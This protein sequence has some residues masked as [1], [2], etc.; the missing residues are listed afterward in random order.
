MSIQQGNHVFCERTK[1]LQLAHNVGLQI[2]QK[3]ALLEGYQVYLVEQWVCDRDRPYKTVKVF[4]GDP[5]HKI[6]VCVIRIEDVRDSSPALKDLLREMEKDVASRMKPV[7]TTDTGNIMV[8]DPSNFSS[9]LDMVLVP[10]GD[11]EKH[12]QAFCV[13]VN[14]RRTQCGGRSALNLSN[15]TDAQQDKFR[16]LYKIAGDAMCFNDSVLELVQLAQTSLHIFDLL[17][18]EYIDGLICDK[19]TTALENFY[20]QLGPSDAAPEVG[21]P[22]FACRLRLA[23]FCLREIW[24]EPHLLALLLSKLVNYKNKLH[25]LGYPHV[26]D[27]FEIEPF[28]ICIAAFQKYTK[29]ETQS[30]LLD[31]LTLKTLNELTYSTQTLKMPRVLKSKIDDLSVSAGISNAPESVETNDLET[32][33]IKN[34]TIERLKILWRPKGKIASQ[35]D[36]DN[37]GDWLRGGKFLLKTVGGIPTKTGGVAVDLIKNVAGNVAGSLTRMSAV[38]PRPRMP[39]RKPNSRTNSNKS[40]TSSTTLSQQNS[41]ASKERPKRMFVRTDELASGEGSSSDFNKNPRHP[42]ALRIDTGV[43]SRASKSINA[44]GHA[45][46]LSTP[47]SPVDEYHTALKNDAQLRRATSPVSSG[48]T[49][50][51]SAPPRRRQRSVSISHF[52]LT[53]PVV[54]H[55]RLEVDQHPHSPMKHASS[56][57]TMPSLAANTIP[58]KRVVMDVPTYILYE[59]MM[60]K[61]A[62][63]KTTFE[64]LQRVSE[65]LDT[66]SDKL[67]ATWLHRSKELADLQDSARASFT[68]QNDTAEQLKEMD[69]ECA[70]LQYELLVLEDKLKEMEEFV[71]SFADKVRTKL[72]Y[73][74]ETRDTDPFR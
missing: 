8:T 13:N 42:S 70:K 11:F 55:D 53:S 20:K 47:A 34:I 67:H 24:L 6:R 22:S 15:P 68:R 25:S 35:F 61:E 73:H 65:T 43:S 54:P 18:V 41:M 60:Q 21:W 71:D 3:D 12:I 45:Q 16:M 10:D 64:K 4:T 5:H 49:E 2:V 58:R 14:L 57:T 74:Y 28:K 31:T 44:M 9:N 62:K 40:G 59:A 33:I 69:V 30:R 46:S 38:D 72:G 32:F 27:P 52:P 23:M 26:K 48:A 37:P 50:R 1:I 51:P 63:F 19:T 17:P 7:L 56:F 36:P 66:Q 39:E 29:I